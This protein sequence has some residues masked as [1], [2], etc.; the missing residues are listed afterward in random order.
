[1][2]QW[3]CKMKYRNYGK[4]TAIVILLTFSM[5]P[6]FGEPPTTH[7]TIITEG[8]TKFYSDT[9]VGELIE[10]LSEAA[11][12]AIERA[13]GEAAKAATLA[14][15][16]RETT[17]IREVQRWRQEYGEARKRGIKAAIITG[18]I[19]FFGGLAVGAGAVTIIGGR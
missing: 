5:T 3:S 1:M 6:V 7:G 4:I 19:C 11:E 18:V 17:A 14:S 16:E 8:S 12:Q 13:A 10:E 9:E 15:L 2:K